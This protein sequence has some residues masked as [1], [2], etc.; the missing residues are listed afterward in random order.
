[1][2][3]TEHK[4]ECNTNA[5][6]GLCL[7]CLLCLFVALLAVVIEAFGFALVADFAGFRFFG[8]GFIIRCG[9]VVAVRAEMPDSAVAL[10][11][12]S[13]SKGQSS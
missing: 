7:L 3:R 13:H 1:M 10:A 8:R 5:S 6:S 12:I 4:G 2:S 11:S 9:P